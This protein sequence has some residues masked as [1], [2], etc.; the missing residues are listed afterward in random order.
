MVVRARQALVRPNKWHHIFLTYEGN[1]LAKGLHL[2]V[3]G[4]PVK[5]RVIKDNLAGKSILIVVENLPLALQL[6][7]LDA[8]A[9][10]PAPGLG[11]IAGRGLKA[12]ASPV[13]C[14]AIQLLAI[15]GDASF[16][17]ESTSEP[18]PMETD[19]IGYARAQALA[20]ARQKNGCAEGREAQARGGRQ[21]GESQQVASRRKGPR[22]AAQVDAYPTCA[23]TDP[24]GAEQ[25]VGEP[26]G[27]VVAGVDE[28]VVAVERPPL[29]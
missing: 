1:G 24:F 16:V 3:D 21:R 6:R 26:D 15:A 12:G 23:P 22:A 7:M 9:A 2:Y 25:L 11:E 29:V 5:I 14:A 18:S 13:R 19:P 20:V 28:V 17:R 10:H 8:I 4:Q 27:V